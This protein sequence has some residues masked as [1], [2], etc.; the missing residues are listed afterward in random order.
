[1][2]PASTREPGA[3]YDAPSASDRLQA[4]KGGSMARIDLQA[5]L[6]YGTAEPDLAMVVVTQDEDGRG[7]FPGLLKSWTNLLRCSFDRTSSTSTS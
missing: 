1:M 7:V 4:G 5:S 6:H 3:S 2:A